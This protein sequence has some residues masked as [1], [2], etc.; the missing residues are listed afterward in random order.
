[1]LYFC[2]GF[3]VVSRGPRIAQAEMEAEQ[4]KGYELRGAGDVSHFVF[5]LF[6]LS[7]N[8]FLTNALG[9]FVDCPLQYLKRAALYTIGFLPYPP[10]ILGL[11]KLKSW[12][13]SICLKILN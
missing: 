4:G 13:I 6:V 7:S 9:L 11:G 5:N 3:I 8:L 1:M 12:L 10:T 2:K